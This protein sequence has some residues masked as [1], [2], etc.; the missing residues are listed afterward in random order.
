METPSIVPMLVMESGH[1]MLIP[2]LSV[3]PVVV[4]DMKV[5]MVA[6]VVAPLIPD[7]DPVGVEVAPI[8]KI[9]ARNGIGPVVTCLSPSRTV[10]P[11]RKLTRT[12]VA[13]SSRLPRFRVG[14]PRVVSPGAYLTWQG[15]SRTTA[16][17]PVDAGAIF[18]GPIRD[19]WQCGHPGTRGHHGASPASWKFTRPDR[20]SRDGSTG[21]QRFVQPQKIVQR[22]GVGAGLSTR[23]STTRKSRFCLG[24]GSDRAIAT[25]AS[26][27]PRI[28]AGR[29]TEIRERRSCGTSGIARN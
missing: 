24:P 16:S 19:S 5:P 11:R 10:G 13:R 4:V 2:P 6:E 18:S 7:L 9:W 28:F 17:R 15:L 21:S 27:N 1:V 12:P 14:F 20:R 26:G 3:E 8:A 25:G 29:P 23:E 22:A